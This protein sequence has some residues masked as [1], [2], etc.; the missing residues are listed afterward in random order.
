MPHSYGAVFAFVGRCVVRKREA[1]NETGTKISTRMTIVRIGRYWL[2]LAPP[3]RDDSPLG[4]GYPNAPRRSWVAASGAARRAR[5][6]LAGAASVS[7]RDQQ[8]R[9]R[10]RPSA[11]PPCTP[12]P[13]DRSRRG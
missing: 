5:T 2:T 13:R 1:R 8:G 9:G 3:F 12:P 10:A 7:E 4:R 6:E 11:R